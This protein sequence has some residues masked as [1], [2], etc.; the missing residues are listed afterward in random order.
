MLDL[1]HAQDSGTIIRY[2][3][4]LIHHNNKQASKGEVDYKGSVR[5]REETREKRRRCPFPFIVV[6]SARLG[7]MEFGNSQGFKDFSFCSTKDIDLPLRIRISSLEQLSGNDISVATEHLQELYVSCQLLSGEQQ[8]LSLPMRTAYK[9]F[10]TRWAYVAMDGGACTVAVTMLDVLRWNEWITLPIKYRDLPADAWLAF[11]VWEITGPHQ[12]RITASTA[13]PLFNRQN[14]LRTGRQKLLLW[15]EA[16]PSL[17]DTPAWSKTPDILDR[18]EQMMKRHEEGEII[19]VDWL[20]K[21]AFREIERIHNMDET[22]RP[23]KLNDPAPMYLSLLDPELDAENIVEAKHRRLVRSHRNGAVDRDLKPEARTRDQLNAIIQYA[24]TQPLT[25][26]EKDLLWKFRFYL[27]R[28]KRVG[29]GVYACM[30]ACM[31][32]GS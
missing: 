19:R 7:S 5:K 1:K 10:K 30:H 20:D 27:S 18:L 32:D 9:S 21:L 3:H 26:E 11:S 31:V 25:S 22:R 17:A 13:F 2:G 4:I 16:K 24:P 28:D 6:F 23:V 29:S 14:V 12:S 8:T 15:R